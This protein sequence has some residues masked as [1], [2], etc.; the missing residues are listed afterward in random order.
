MSENN[1]ETKK[2]KLTFAGGAGWVTGANFLLEKPDFK[3]L[4]DCGLIQG[5]HLAEF[6]NWEPFPY[7]PASVDVLIITHAH[8]D[9]IGRIPKLVH[10]GFN[11]KIISTNA[12]KDLA[13]VM[14]RDTA[15]ILSGS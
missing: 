2:L 5:E 13:A 11:G 14:I 1:K 15:N 10:E 6:E 9:H 3:L 7:D 12:T 8:I 4:I